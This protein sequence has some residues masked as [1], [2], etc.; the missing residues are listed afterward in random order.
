MKRKTEGMTSA[1]QDR[2]CPIRNHK[3]TIMKEQGNEKCWTCDERDDTVMHILSEYEKLVQ[4]KYKKRHD[5]VALIIHWEL[6]G[7]IPHSSQ[8]MIKATRWYP[9][10]AE[11]Q[12]WFN[13]RTKPSFETR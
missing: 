12:K 8:W 1:A 6:C 5:C 3:V 2:L 10:I 11:K 4:G 13:H 9:C 7:M